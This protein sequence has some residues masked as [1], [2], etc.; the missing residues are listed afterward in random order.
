MSYIWPDMGVPRVVCRQSAGLGAFNRAE[1]K[2]RILSIE[3]KYANNCY[4]QL[5]I[6]AG[7][8]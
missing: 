8:Y 1:E 5:I 2:D 4:P 6:N 3:T 7:T